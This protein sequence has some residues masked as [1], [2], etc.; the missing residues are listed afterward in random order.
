[1]VTADARVVALDRSIRQAVGRELKARNL[2]ADPAEVAAALDVQRQRGTALLGAL[3]AHCYGV[4]AGPGVR[5]EF[6]DEADLER[7]VLALAFGDLTGRLLGSRTAGGVVPPGLLAATFNLGIGLVDGL[8]DRDPTVGIPLLERVAEADLRAGAASGWPVGH[9]TTSLPTP[10][11]ASPAALF[12]ARV[13]EAVIE[14]LHEEYPGAA[15]AATRDGV[16]ALLSDALA[17]ER[18]SIAWRTESSRDSLLECSRATSVLPFRIIEL[19]A[20]GE[21]DRVGRTSA[22]LL[23]EAMWL[24]DDLADLVADLG[25][26]ALNGVILHARPAPGA[27]GPAELAARLLESGTVAA[28]AASAAELL[29][30]GLARSRGSDMDQAGFLAFVQAYVGPVSTPVGDS[31]A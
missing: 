24:L 12:T 20:T 14:L 17:A 11:L 2:A 21:R 1:M 6:G 4:E 16:G 25:D 23:G 5:V 28:S 22:D 9:L 7:V 29:G 30:E 19:L 10:L 15:G 3:V 8:C 18:R 26:G 31:D 27:T 13:I